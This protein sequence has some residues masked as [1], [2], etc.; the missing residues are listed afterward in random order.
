MKSGL[1]SRVCSVPLNEGCNP[2]T[3]V[4]MARLYKRVA[5]RFMSDN[6]HD[7]CHEGIKLIY[8]PHRRQ[9]QSTVR[10]NTIYEHMYC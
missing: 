6:P 7:F 2:L 3:K 4:D 9:N 1:S 5:E 8:S 10:K